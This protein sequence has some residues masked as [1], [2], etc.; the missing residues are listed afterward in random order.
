MVVRYLLV[1]VILGVAVGLSFLRYT[2]Q[3]TF[4][5][6]MVGQPTDL[7][8][9]SGPKNE[10]DEMLEN[11][12]FRSLFKYDLAGNLTND[13]VEGYEVKEGGKV[14]E[15]TL[16][17]GIFWHDGYPVV[18][19]DVRFTLNQD[20][21]FSKAVIEVVDGKKI[22]F[23]LEDPLGSFPSLLTKLI[24]P[25][26]L[27]RT[28]P[29]TVVGDGSFYINHIEQD[30]EV[31]EITLQN[32]GT[33][34]IR[35]LVF[36]FFKTQTDLQEAAKRGEVDAFVADNFNH[37]SF[38]RYQSPLYGRYF[39]IFFNLESKNRMVKSPTF[40]RAAARKTPIPILLDDP[41]KDGGVPVHGPLSGTFAEANLPFP[42]FSLTIKAQFKGGL[43]L[44]VPN[45]GK[46]PEVAKVITQHWQMLGIKV[47][48]ETVS[49]TMIEEIIANKDFEAIILG[50]EVSRDPDRYSLWH[51]TQ[52]V[53]PGLNIT[54]YSDPRADR[55][56]EEGR[57]T[58]Q[59]S[60]RKEH[61]LN[62]QRLF[63]EDNPAIFLYHPNLNYFVSRRFSGINLSSLFVPSERFRNIQE[64]VQLPY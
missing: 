39:A 49:T 62:F 52:K 4:T 17:N 18:A 42:K 48:I 55:A 50:Q 30:G 8:P 19:E 58:I 54:S 25:S 46:L 15:I 3:A 34:K 35:S 45:I 47:N 37:P 12:L 26:H 6:G 29:L 23:R 7:N 9:T 5:E 38:T 40:R 31:K 27:V 1:A 14:Y 44:T 57:K 53:Y 32:Q 2:P 56:L 51:S 24:A 64:W 36:K 63:L 43:T 10:V 61:Y 33:G 21:T 20:P 28:S 11:L 59:Q 13:L 16:K 41:L 60:K 22:R